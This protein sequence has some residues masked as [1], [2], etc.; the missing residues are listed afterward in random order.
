MKKAINVANLYLPI[1]YVNYGRDIICSM[2]DNLILTYKE[3]AKMFDISYSTFLTKTSRGEFAK[4]RIKT[5]RQHKR[6]Y[7][8]H[9]E[10]KAIYR[11]TGGFIVNE[12]F[13][14]LF[15]N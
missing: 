10:K 2:T 4:F 14:K 7:K 5:K 8:N 13:K 11:I 3:T 1:M 15:K 6:K 12:E 9:K